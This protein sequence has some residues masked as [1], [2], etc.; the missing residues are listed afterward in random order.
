VSRILGVQGLKQ[1]GGWKSRVCL[2][3]FEHQFQVR[4][5]EL[6]TLLELYFCVVCSIGV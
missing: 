5:A 6:C 1:E 4:G 2:F 3:N